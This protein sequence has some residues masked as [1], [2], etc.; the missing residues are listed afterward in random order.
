MRAP[1]RV[2]WTSR[3]C[4]FAGRRRVRVVAAGVAAVSGVLA[5]GPARG[6]ADRGS[7]A[8]AA[9]RL[10]VG[11]PGPGWRFASPRTSLTFSGVDASALGEVRVIGSRSG[12]HTGR[13]HAFRAEPGGV[14]VPD[15]RFAP[16]E[17]VRV[18]VA[19]RVMG[20]SGGSFSFVVSRPGGSRLQPPDFEGSGRFLPGRPQRTGVG[21]CRLRRPRFRTRP[22][23]RPVGLCLSRGPE[24]G[25]ARGR[26]L[27]APRSHPERYR[28][29]STA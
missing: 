15:R 26:I 28:G 18:Q 20:A 21:T 27:V 25:T 2:A 12:P 6:G 10:V 4:R 8:A 3:D 24:R 29:T 16:G 11:Y 22:G 5:I 14:F 17:R 19:A 13:L 1:G 23:F 9:K 7:R